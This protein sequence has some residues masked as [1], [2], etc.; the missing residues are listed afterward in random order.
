MSK[1]LYI[2]TRFNIG[3]HLHPD[4]YEYESYMQRRWEWFRATTVP[5]VVNQTC[6]NFK[7]LVLIDKQTPADWKRMMR[8]EAYDLIEIDGEAIGVTDAVGDE[9]QRRIGREALAQAGHRG[10][11]L[12]LTARL[13]SDDCLARHYV[14]R[15]RKALRRPQ[16]G[17]SFVQGFYW[18]HQE[19]R[20]GGLFQSRYRKNMFP[21]VCGVGKTVFEIDHPR[22]HK[23]FEMQYEA[24]GQMWLHNWL[25]DGMN[26]QNFTS[27]NVK[28][29][30]RPKCQGGKKAKMNDR[31]IGKVFG[32]DI[33]RA[34]EIAERWNSKDC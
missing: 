16:Q 34:K 27:R 3:L 2:L 15:V 19:G 33:E 32:I 4:R 23:R 25:P 12:T 14:W 29:T 20:W 31:H 21:A 6:T 9:H 5:S 7:W 18:Y 8:G 22:L 1:Q 24:G 13:D 10:T 26:L 11:G 28:R 30:G 17:V